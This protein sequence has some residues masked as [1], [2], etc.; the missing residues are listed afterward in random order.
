[1]TLAYDNDTMHLVKSKVVSRACRD[2]IPLNRF[3]ICAMFPSSQ[4]MLAMLS[5]VGR[6]RVYMF[7]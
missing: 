4:E 6:S 2:S 7:V 5:G 1:M 3:D